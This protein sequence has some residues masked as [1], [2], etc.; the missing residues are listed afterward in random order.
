[1]GGRSLIL[2]VLLPRTDR[3]VL[4]QTLVTLLIAPLPLIALVRQG[5]REAAW[6]LAGVI[7]MWVAL[8]GLRTLH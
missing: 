6:L 5:K 8:L 1:M 2:E 7:T 4:F 3:G